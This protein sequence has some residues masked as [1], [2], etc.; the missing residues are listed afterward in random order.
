MKKTLKERI[1]K[2]KIAADMVRRDQINDRLKF[3]AENS[4][5]NVFAALSTSQEGLA[6]EQ[7]EQ[8]R[9]LHGDNNV[10]HGKKNLFSKDFATHSS[11]LL[12]QSYLFW[13]SFPP[14]QKSSGQLPAKKMPQPLS[15]SLLWYWYPVSCVLY[16]KHAAAMR[17]QN[18]LL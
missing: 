11:I 13:Q 5:K 3:A 18:C 14:A 17:Q 4:R 7:V 15:S 16:R 2:T 6:D 1:L 12:L 8:L 10:T 9:E